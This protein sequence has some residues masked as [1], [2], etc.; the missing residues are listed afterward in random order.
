MLDT[1]IGT[2]ATNFNVP[3]RI[4]Y[5][6]TIKPVD[7]P[8]KN[9]LFGGGSYTLIGMEYDKHRYGYQFAIGGGN[10]PVIKHRALF[11]GSWQAWKTCITNTDLNPE[12]YIVPKPSNNSVFTFSNTFQVSVRKSG[13]VVT[14]Q[15]NISAS[16]AAAG[17]FVT[18]FTIPQKYKPL[19]DVVIN[20]IVQNTNKSMVL[21][22]TRDGEVKFSNLNSAIDD[23]LCRQCVTYV[24]N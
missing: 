14:I 13:K 7:D 21:F 22:I 10:T 8:D 5:I 15:L 6:T 17:D 9:F 24:T 19:T 4:T 11:Q 20:Y 23:W 12:V 2:I 18:A 16:M 1:E 3:E